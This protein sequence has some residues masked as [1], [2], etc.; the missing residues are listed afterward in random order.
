VKA[1]VSITANTSD[2]GVNKLGV[3]T[4]LVETIMQVEHCDI[5]STQVQ[6]TGTTNMKLSELTA[7]LYSN[8]D[9]AKLLHN[10]T[11]N[12]G[13]YIATGDAQGV[14]VRKTHS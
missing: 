6:F 8:P 2:R 7:A 13:A 3:L 9:A 14:F 11:Y 10:I 12:V 5:N 1:D 4:Q